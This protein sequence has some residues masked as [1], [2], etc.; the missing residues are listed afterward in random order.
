MRAAEFTQQSR[1]LLHDLH[2]RPGAPQRR[3][4]VNAERRTGN[5][6]RRWGKPQQNNDPECDRWLSGS[7]RES[8]EKR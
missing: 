7:R 2:H 8:V 6:T 4:G 5:E 3:T 1:P